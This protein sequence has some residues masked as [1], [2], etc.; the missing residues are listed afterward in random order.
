MKTIVHGLEDAVLLRWQF[1]P[2]DLQIQSDPN[3]NSTMW[4]LKI[5]FGNF[6]LKLIWKLKGPKNTF[7]MVHSNKTLYYDESILYLHCSVW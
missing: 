7:K 3:H 2:N 5:E 6:I 4:F 1:F